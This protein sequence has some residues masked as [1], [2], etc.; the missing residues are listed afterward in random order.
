MQKVL[1][2]QKKA[3][4][5]IAG[6][7][8]LDSCR[9]AFKSLGLLTVVS[10]YIEEAVIHAIAKTPTRRGEV[11]QYNLRN[12]TQ[13]NLL[14][15]RTTQFEKKPSYMGTKLHNLLPPDLRSKNE[16]ELPPAL[17]KWLIERPFYSM[18]E[19]YQQIFDF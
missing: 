14:A 3:I 1:K 12:S 11:H 6:L 8:R 18:E 5:I 7:Q 10:L 15:H 4:K 19:F 13:Y 2:K 16:R 17:H 9:E